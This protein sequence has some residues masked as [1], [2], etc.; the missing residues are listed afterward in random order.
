MLEVQPKSMRVELTVVADRPATLAG[1]V[2]SPVFA[3]ASSERIP[4]FPL[5]S[6]AVTL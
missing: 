2:E 6:T 1:A 3:D 5:L 4:M